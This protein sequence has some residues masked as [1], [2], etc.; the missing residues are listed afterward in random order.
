MFLALVG[1]LVAMLGAAITFAADLPCADVT[2]GARRDACEKAEI[3]KLDAEL[4]LAYAA[5]L[6]AS[7]RPDALRQEQRAWVWGRLSGHAGS[8]FAASLR[9]HT[10]RIAVLRM[11]M[12]TAEPGIDLRDAV[13]GRYGQMQ[14]LCFVS[15]KAKNGMECEG[16]APS[17]MTLLPVD[18]ARARLIVDTLFFNGHSCSFDAVGTWNGDVLEFSEEGFEN[19]DIRP[20]ACKLKLSFKAGKLLS[21]DSDGGCRS[22]CGAR[23]SLSNGTGE[24]K[25]PVS[26][27]DLRERSK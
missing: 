8:D 19:G 9:F 17:T 3:T 24:P 21:L 14:R 18:K 7:K 22:A 5:A 6:K 23:G 15:Q 12:R 1:G 13:M 2:A 25:W 4:N 20:G 11:R 27:V 26:A 16:E 10:E